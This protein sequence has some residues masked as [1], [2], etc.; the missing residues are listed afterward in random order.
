MSIDIKH[1]PQKRIC[2]DFYSVIEFLKKYGAK[3][4]NKNWHW[5]RWEWLLGHLALDELTLP[6][7]GLFMENDEIVGLVTHD[8]RAQ[9][10]IILNPQYGY[11]KPPMVDYAVKELSHEGISSIY[12]DEKDKELI[13]IVKEKGYL[14]TENSEYVLELNCKEI[15]S[16]S[17]DKDF[18]F[19]DYYSDKDLMQYVKVIHNGF[20]NEGEP[21]QLTESDIP[22]RP[23]YDPKLALFIVAPNGDYAAHCGTWYSPDTETCYVEPVVTVPDFR[24]CGLGKSVVYE[25]INR[26]VSMGAKKALVI[27]NQQFYHR[28]GFK[29]YS[30]HR[31]WEK[32]VKRTE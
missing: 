3:G 18:Y 15:L 6:T 22:E 23:H 30:V 24:K 5:A 9:A 25:C 7:I 28:L 14:V 2:Q 13:E 32:T 31:L 12:I 1:Y 10:Y 29:E 8:M 26:C 20:E 21:T 19:T 4:N 11:L 16:Y 27:S 17:L